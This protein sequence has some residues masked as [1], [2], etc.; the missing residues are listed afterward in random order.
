ME[1]NARARPNASSQPPAD[2]ARTGNIHATNRRTS[3]IFVLF[4]LEFLF[5]GVWMILIS[6][7][8]FAIQY[9]AL[10]TSCGVVIGL[11]MGSVLLLLAIYKAPSYAA[12]VVYTRP[13]GKIKEQFIAVVKPGQTWYILPL[14]DRVIQEIPITHYQ[15]RISVLNAPT[16]SKPVNCT[17]MVTY[18]I[19]AW[20]VGHPPPEPKSTQEENRGAAQKRGKFQPR[21]HAPKRDRGDILEQSGKKTTQERVPEEAYLAELYHFSPEKWRQRVQS[22]GQDVLRKLL[23]EKT[24]KHWQK[25][26]VNLVKVFQRRLADRLAP[27]GIIIEENNVHLL[28]FRPTPSAQHLQQILEETRANKKILQQRLQL[29]EKIIKDYGL[30]TT[31]AD[32]LL[33]TL[34]ILLT[35]K[36]EEMP[37]INIQIAA[38]SDRTAKA[39]DEDEPRA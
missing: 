28:D 37:N 2:S 29:L 5:L 20:N 39:T 11:L 30:P 4:L 32:L 17:F 27:W 1:P 19:E 18:H 23:A 31:A 26:T 16:K 7:L 6:R 22:T 25:N 38:P 33:S 8:P 24:Y 15:A 36:P 3:I 9:F 14:W 21:N 35:E 13:F 34:T 10:L 12:G